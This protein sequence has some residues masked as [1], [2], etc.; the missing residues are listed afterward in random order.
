LGSQPDI[1]APS[2]DRPESPANRRRF[3][4]RPGVIVRFLIE[5]CSGISDSYGEGFRKIQRGLNVGMGRTES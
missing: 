5:V 4:R 2:S 1:D 3:R